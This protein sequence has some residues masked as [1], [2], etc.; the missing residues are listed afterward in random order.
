MIPKMMP[1]MK[2]D[3]KKIKMKLGQCN[4]IKGLI[5]KMY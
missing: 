3:I 2:F 5:I 1:K 4:I